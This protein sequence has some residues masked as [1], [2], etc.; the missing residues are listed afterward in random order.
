MIHPTI[1]SALSGG[2]LPTEKPVTEVYSEICTRAQ[3]NI[4]DFV[5]SLHL[6]SEMVREL[7][8]LEQVMLKE[9]EDIIDNDIEAD[10]RAVLLNA[11]RLNARKI[12][13]RQK[14][15][16][17]RKEKQRGALQSPEEGITALVTMKKTTEEKYERRTLE[18]TRILSWISL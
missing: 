9:K 14:I 17:T 13:D 4:A 18:W 10:M 6:T 3:S 2:Q 1:S 7:A 12:V 16:D 11:L 8:E 5:S 15:S